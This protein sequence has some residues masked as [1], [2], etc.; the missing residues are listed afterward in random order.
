MST[1]TN[2]RQVKLS[3]SQTSKSS[4]L[5]WNHYRAEISIELIGSLQGMPGYPP[6]IQVSCFSPQRFLPTGL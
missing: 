6:A 2:Q 3:A 5:L 1:H 4:P